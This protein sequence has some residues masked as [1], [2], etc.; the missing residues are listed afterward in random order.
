MSNIFPWSAKNMFHMHWV[1]LKAQWGKTRLNGMNN[2]RV[3]S[4]QSS[5]TFVSSCV[6]L[7]QNTSNLMPSAGSTRQQNERD[8]FLLIELKLPL[9]QQGFQKWSDRL[10][11]NHSTIALV[12]R[13]SPVS[14]HQ[15]SMPYTVAIHS[16]GTLLIMVRD[17][18]YIKMRSQ[19]VFQNL[20]HI[21]LLN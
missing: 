13:Q 12:S 1:G 4:I 15:A 18:S 8:G 6:W 17:S 5:L 20:I 3:F 16:Y 10:E 9:T 21:Q 19:K 14:K 7:R 2:Q 11:K